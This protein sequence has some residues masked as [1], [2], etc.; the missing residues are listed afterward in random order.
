MK[1]LILLLAILTGGASFMF[2]TGVNHAADGPIWV[3]DA[4]RMAQ[5]LCDRP[6]LLAS[7]T[8]GLIALWLAMLFVSAIRD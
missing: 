2:Y 4:C 3:N 8:I 7:A 6:Q 1:N 5:D